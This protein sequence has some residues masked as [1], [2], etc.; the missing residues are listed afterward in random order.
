M[1]DIICHNICVSVRERVEWKEEAGRGGGQRHKIAFRI[2]KYGLKML[3][4]QPTET[5]KD[6]F[7]REQREKKTLQD[8]FQ[9]VYGDFRGPTTFKGC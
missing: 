7:L 2:H 8:K 6:K 9:R 5:A 4:P 1:P 3:G